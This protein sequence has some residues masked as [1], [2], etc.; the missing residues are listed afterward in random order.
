MG[1][2]DTLLDNRLNIIKYFV[3]T[4]N[5][6]VFDYDLEY[7]KL[8]DTERKPVESFIKQLKYISQWNS[9]LLE[10]DLILCKDFKK[11]IEE[12]IKQYPDKI[13]NFFTRPN[14][15]FTTHESS[16]F[17]YNQCTYY[18]KGVAFKL[19]VKMEEGFK[20]N[21]RAQYDILE[22]NALREL[23]ITHVQYRPCLVQHLDKD[24][25]V[26]NMAQ[27]HRRSPYFIDYLEELNIDYSSSFKEENRNK[28][29]NLLFS[30]KF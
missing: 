10:D 3:R 19:A 6:R 14:D 23:G 16:T 7:R 8:I 1:F 24:S 29:E 2:I 4:T 12:V 5:D 30:K 15:Y 17:A 22:N 9:V 18:P 28:L 13:I 11:K 27:G 21:P 25:L 20:R 26:G